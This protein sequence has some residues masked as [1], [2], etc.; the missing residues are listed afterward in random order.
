MKKFWLGLALTIFLAGCTL[1]WQ[2]IAPTPVEMKQPTDESVKLVVDDGQS[3][4]TY[5]ATARNG[6]TALEMTQEIAA[7]ENIEVR[8]KQYDFGV[9]LEAI[10]EKI[11]TPDRVW[12]LFVNGTGASVGASEQRVT[13]GDTI[14]WRYITPSL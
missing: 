7:K 11:N 10:G 4:A 5:G 12:I 6:L 2:K 9:I 1:P 3:V 14:E 13:A 8:L